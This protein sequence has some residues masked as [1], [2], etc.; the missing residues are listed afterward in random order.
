MAPA[1]LQ[2]GERAHRQ[3]SEL[4]QARKLRVQASPRRER[5]VHHALQALWPCERHRLTERGE[6]RGVISMA[7]PSRARILA[8]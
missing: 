3:V 7:D 1:A 5:D 2:L 4:D 8:T 6:L